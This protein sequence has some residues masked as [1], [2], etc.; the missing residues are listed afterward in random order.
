MMHEDL[1][2]NRF[3]SNLFAIKILI[4]KQKTRREALPA[5]SCG[6]TVLLTISPASGNGN[7]LSPK[8]F[9]FFATTKLT[10][11]FIAFF[12]L[13]AFEKAIVLNFFLQNPHGFFEIV[14]EDFDFYSFQ[15]GST[16]LFPIASAIWLYCFNHDGYF[17][18]F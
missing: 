1:S 12:Q 13:Q 15:T 10:R 11:F 8:R 17:Y 4:P 18:S 9:A 16:P 7:A 5:G 6:Q 3:R 14:V 2:R